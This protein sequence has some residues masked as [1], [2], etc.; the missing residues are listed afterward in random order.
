MIG[1]ESKRL[2]APLGRV[3]AIGTALPAHS[4]TQ[5]E[6]KQQVRDLFSDLPENL[7]RVFDNAGIARRRFA[8]P[9]GYHRSRPSFEQRNRDFVRF[10]TDLSEQAIRAAL[11]R[12]ELGVR[13]VDHLLL[14]TTTGL[15]TPSLDALLFHRLGFRRDAERTP[16]WG[17]GCGAGAAGLSRASEY[18][19]A[20]PDRVAL[21]ASVELCAQTF[22][23]DDNTTENLVAAALFGDGA[24]AAVVGG[25]RRN[26]GGVEVLAT[27]SVLFPETLDLMG[28][29]IRDTGFRVVMSRRIPEFVRAHVRHEVD[30]FLD[31]HGLARRDIGTFVLHPGGPKVVQSLEEALE[32][33]EGALRPSREFLRE[34][35]NLS[36]ASV[37]FILDRILREG[38]PA[39]SLGLLMAMGPGFSFEF[40]LLRF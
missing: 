39:G 8:A 2:P 11:Q 36:S 23:P 34:C 26:R 32:L 16:I 10:A 33:P 1:S 31:I 38:R 24:A 40:S 18:V 5:E 6:I 15:A 25:T 20:F 12:A 3:E 28:W 14:V 9:P 30:V 35:G 27:R 7:L 4:A 37:L 21:L 22:Q 17:L 13:D 29:D 19:R